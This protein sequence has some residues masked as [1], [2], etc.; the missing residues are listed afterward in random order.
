MVRCQLGGYS[1]Y[2]GWA[3]KTDKEQWIRAPCGEELATHTG[4]ESC[5]DI[6]KA[7]SEALTV[8]ARAG[9]L[10]RERYSKLQGADAV[11]SDERALCFPKINTF[12]NSVPHNTH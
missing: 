8:C 9:L 1:K 4:T 2:C 5:V 6:R 11:H 12:S 7:I 3:E 10:S